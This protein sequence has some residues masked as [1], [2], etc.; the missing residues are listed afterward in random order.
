MCLTMIL[1]D[2]R[3]LSQA[4]Q[5]LYTD[6]Q[7]QVYLRQGDKF[8]EVSSQIVQGAKEAK[9]SIPEFLKG[10][11]SGKYAI[12]DDGR[13]L[14]QAT[15]GV[16]RDGQGQVYVKEQDKFSQVSSQVVQSAKEALRIAIL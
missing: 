12:L 15:D 11:E 8:S 4:G 13:F 14:I 9:T 5:D 10:L 7:G 1:G 3:L 6:S 2:G 16:Y